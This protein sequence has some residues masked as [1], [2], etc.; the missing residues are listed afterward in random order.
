[1]HEFIFLPIRREAAKAINHV[2]A[3]TP[4]DPNIAVDDP[5]DVSLCLAI[6]PAHVPDLGV[7]AQVVGITM[8]A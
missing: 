3:Y 6:A 7:R 4:T 2:P 1:M 5:D 8:F